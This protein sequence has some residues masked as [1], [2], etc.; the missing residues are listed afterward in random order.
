MT[1]CLNLLAGATIFSINIPVSMSLKIYFL[2]DAKLLDV[3][4]RIQLEA[5]IQELANK[6][7]INKTIEL[8]EVEELSGSAQAIG[9]AMLPGRAVILIDPKFV[10]QHSNEELEFVLAHELSHIKANDRIWGQIVTLTAGLITAFAM[11]ILF[12]SSHVFEILIVAM[13]I[14][15]ILHSRWREEC[16]DKLGLTVCSDPA[17]KAASQVFEKMRLSIMQKRDNQENSL[18][19]K[20]WYKYLISEEGDDLL[21]VMHPPLTERIKY[22]NEIANAV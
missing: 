21:D 1:I 18:F 11:F 5:K 12:P 2:K 9:T 3:E 7:D 13:T 15:A 14:A 10:S 8:I 20:L 19:S 16:A 6:L 17:K 22:L 4:K